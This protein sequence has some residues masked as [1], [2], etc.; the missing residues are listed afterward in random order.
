M[1]V[2]L[3]LAGAGLVGRQH[4]A[5]IDACAGVALAA[6]ADPADAGRMLAAAYGVPWF[7]SLDELLAAAAPD[8]VMVATPNH[9]HVENGLSCVRARVPFLVEK[10]VAESAD[11][12]WTLV[13]AAAAAGV[14][15]LAGH[16]RRHNPL[17]RRAREAIAD[18]ALG[19]LRTVHGV[20]WLYK[21]DAYFAEAAW[22]RARGAGPV[23]VNLVHDV[24]L[25]RF[26]C[27]EVESVQA[28]AAD[29]VRG[30]ENEDA[31]VAILRFASGV[32]GTVTVSDSVA[33]PW[34]WELTARE[35]P[36]YPWTGQSCYFLGGARGALSVPDLRLWRYGGE[37]SWWAP[38]SSEALECEGGNPLVAQV[39]QL[40]AVIAEG[41]P[42][43]VSG[44]EGV[45]ALQVVEAIARAA[46]SGER[47]GLG[48]GA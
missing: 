21:P 35:N 30:F 6:V 29:A 36:V 24:D 18:G 13:R 14:P 31:A 48:E 16:H 1:T 2:R 25:L 41:V 43:L 11:A 23:A 15:M 20:C 47:V 28:M 26:F 45:R 8:G 9:A 38:L 44:A 10:P 34:S 39:A 19:E 27:G 33:A 3:A 17:V 22:R 40:A 37:R 12:G 7:R 4:A 32:L 42:P 5:A 46:D